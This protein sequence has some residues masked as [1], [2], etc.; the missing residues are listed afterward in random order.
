MISTSQLDQAR[1]QKFM[2]SAR[3]VDPAIGEAGDI[4]TALTTV[5]FANG[6]VGVI[7]NSRQAV[8]GYDQRIEVF[9]SLGCV[10]NSN[11]YGNNT[12]N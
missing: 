9:G 8:Y 2:R 5:K 7:D 1:R 12:G 4:D 10:V 6:A 11:N 3:Y